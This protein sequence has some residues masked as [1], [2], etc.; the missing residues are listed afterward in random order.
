MKTL[1]K[2]IVRQFLINF[3]ILFLVM[4]SLFVLVDLLI[5]LDEFLQAGRQWA[6]NYGG[7]LPATLVAIG[8][9][10]GPMMVLV[11]VFVSGLLV[12]GAM[13]FTL[14]GL[15]RTREL[16]AMVAS[17]ISMYR[18]AAPM[19]VAGIAL[20]A[21]SLPVQ[22]MVVPKLADKLAR[23]KSD[24]KR[25]AVETFPVRFTSDER[26]N[27]IDAQTFDPEKQMLSGVTIIV[28][29]EQGLTQ[30]RI[31]ATQAFWDEDNQ[32]WQLYPSGYVVEPLPRDA[33]P[34]QEPEEVTFFPTEL[35][36]TVLLARRA[37]IYARLFS[38]EELQ[39][40]QDNPAIDASSREQITR[41]MWSRFSLAVMNVLIMVMGMSF[42][43]QLGQGNLLMQ[44][45][46]AAGV[47]LGAWG[48]GLLLLQ[49]G[50][51]WLNPV[52]SAWLPVVIYLPVSAV[53]LQ[54]VK[55]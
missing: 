7:V 12:V 52:A 44:A 6:E 51:G 30:R 19:L 22:E 18:I 3:G 41:I 13:G 25:E 50:A 20:N 4:M 14:A 8:D 39:T 23:S 36:P 55:T 47:C 11:Y 54:F 34:V 9:Y 43:L 5:D 24:V 38:L 29:S 53:L 33:P 28:R 32:G 42:F 17:G 1:D 31:T 16:T 27:L 35:S 48:G 49:A 10:Y 2:Y 37:S 45:V 21:L 26:G 46:Q 40:V 15:Q